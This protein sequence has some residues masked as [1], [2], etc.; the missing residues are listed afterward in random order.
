MNDS[1]KHI[2]AEAQGAQQAAEEQ[3]S[4][5]NGKLEELQQQLRSIRRE[6]HA[7]QEASKET[8]NALKA[9][10]QRLEAKLTQQCQVC[11]FDHVIAAC[12]W[13]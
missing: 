1:W 9:E 5:A 11:M 13:L 4:T 3:V 2:V 7:V 10:V 6:S 8:A 12:L